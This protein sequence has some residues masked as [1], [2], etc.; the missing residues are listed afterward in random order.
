MSRG[1]IISHGPGNRQEAEQKRPSDWSPPS[2][3][4]DVGENVT[5]IM[6]VFGHNQERNRTGKED[7]KVIDDIGLGH[8]LHPVCRKRIDEAIENGQS[9]HDPNGLVGGREPVEIAADRNRRQEQLRRSIFR[10][11]DAGNLT[12]KIDPS[13][14]PADGRDP[15]LR[16]KAGNGVVQTTAGRVRGHKLGHGQGDTHA[17]RA[18]IS[19]DQTTEAEP[20]ASSG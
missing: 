2:V 12:K 9:S 8:L 20:P 17:S 13:H 5:R 1:I 11:S 10:R 6:L 4:L 7:T 3:A 14:N 15:R 19:Q 16:G 18:E